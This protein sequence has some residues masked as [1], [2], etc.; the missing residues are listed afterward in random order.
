MSEL[1]NTEKSN[2]EMWYPNQGWKMAGSIFAR[3][4]WAKFSPVVTFRINDSINLW[5]YWDKK[6]QETLSDEKLNPVLEVC[7]QQHYQLQPTSDIQLE[8]YRYISNIFYFL[9]GN[10]G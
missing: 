3:M 5:M 2:S 10:K 6:K 1:P 8:I 9:Q 7:Q 4:G